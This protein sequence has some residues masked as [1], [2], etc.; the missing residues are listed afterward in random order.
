[1][2]PKR[3]LSLEHPDHMPKLTTR[4]VGPNGYYETVLTEEGEKLEKRKYKNLK[5]F[6]QN[7][8]EKYS[9]WK[10]EFKH[11]ASKFEGK[12]RDELEK[13]QATASRRQSR[14]T[15]HSKAKEAHAADL[16]NYNSSWWRSKVFNPP[17]TPKTPIDTPQTRRG[18][19]RRKRTL[20]KNR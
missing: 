2:P 16:Q 8:P 5:E 1:M 3:N 18:G 15:S 17:K 14:A 6:K 10:K 20:K 9:N 13:E 11:D 12:L 19:K 4:V 7:D